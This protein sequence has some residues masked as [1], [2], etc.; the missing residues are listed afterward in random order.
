[1]SRPALYF[2]SVRHLR[3]TQLA[4][5]LWFALYRPLPDL[6]AAPQLRPVRGP[7]V[8]PLSLAPTL[9]A[10]D[11]FRFLNVER[12]CVEPADWRPADTEKLW[13]YNLHY[14]DD[15]N[16]ADAG[17]RAAWHARLLERW[18]AENP[19]GCGE[20]WEPYPLS[21]RIVNWVKWAARGNTLSA[22]CRAS[23][24]VQARWLTRRLEYHLLGNH[25]FTNAKALVYAGSYF[26][27]PEAERWTRKGLRIISRELREQVLLDGGHFERST[28]YHAA[29]LEDL[30][31]LIN[32]R[33]AYGMRPPATWST[34]VAQMQL[35]LSVMSHPDGD[36]ALFNDAAFGIAGNGAEL[37]AYARRLALPA[38]SAVGESVTVLEPSGYV[39]ATCGAAYLVCDCGPVG[40]D[41]LP[42]HAHADT[43]SFE[44]SLHGRRILVNSGTSQY[45][46]SSERQR[47][48]GTAAH[49]TVVIDGADSSEVWAGF[50]VARRARARV[51]DVQRTLP[52]TIEASHDGYRRLPGRNEHQRR[53]VMDQR[54]L[55]VEDQLSGPFRAAHAFFHLHPGISASA[56]GAMSVELRY[57]ERRVAQLTFDDAASVDIKG[58]T[59]HPRFGVA[60]G[61][62]CVIAQFAG[63]TLT[64]RVLWSEAS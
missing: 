37:D 60:V 63:A 49:N 18:V 6:R 50:R 51:R 53:W 27:G 14:F 61:N 64:T 46:V 2:H 40:P 47:Q 24:A 3:P 23:L 8:A 34:A 25:L 48:R 57:E 55:C 11:T 39:R 31:D 19:P 9:V 13:I 43:L 59:W 35:W 38:A 33:R 42:G 26:D 5:R 30:L 54:S 45:G 62:V 36:I 7:Y 4:A 15:L 22:A 12:R 28:M 29:M 44:L 20:G 21:R 10:P 52:L 58:G 56:S 1:M 16:A 41:Y 32:L 17:L